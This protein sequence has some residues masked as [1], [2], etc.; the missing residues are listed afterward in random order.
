MKDKVTV[1]ICV[2]TYS[3]VMGGADLIKLKNELPVQ[4]KN[5]VHFEG[6]VELEGCNEHSG[7]KPPFA[8]V[9]NKIIEQ[10]SKE[11]IITA[12]ENELR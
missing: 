5:K 10:A 9:N 2:G 7:K 12:I 1:K 3:Y 11:K 4:L 8:Q 6:A